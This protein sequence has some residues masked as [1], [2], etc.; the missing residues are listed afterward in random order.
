MK[1]APSDN[2][3]PPAPMDSGDH[4]MSHNRSGLERM[5][6][7]KK[8]RPKS[9][10]VRKGREPLIRIMHRPKGLSRVSLRSICKIPIAAVIV[11]WMFVLVIALCCLA[12]AHA[13]RW[14]VQRGR[15][16]RRSPHYLARSGLMRPLVL[17]IRER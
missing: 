8:T 9:L 16:H 6:Y 11:G 2:I 17:E 13:V 1:T 12:V 14:A 7:L 3:M 5:A 10:V 4:R 15:R